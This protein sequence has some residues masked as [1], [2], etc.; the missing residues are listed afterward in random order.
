[1]ENY[2]KEYCASCDT[3]LKTK[4]P[5][6]KPKAGLKPQQWDNN[7]PGQAIA[8][9]LATMT[10]SYDGFKY[11]MLITDGMSKFTELCPLRNMTAP[12]VVKNIERNW[13][14]RHGIPTTLLTDQGTQV[15]GVEVRDLCE[16]YNIKKQ[17]SSPYH[18]EGD[19]ISERPIGVMKGLF[20]RKIADDNMAQRKWTDLVPGVQLAMNQKIHSSTGTSPFQLMYGDNKR[21][22]TTKPH[23]QGTFAPDQRLNTE[24]RGYSK[25]MSIAKAQQK[26]KSTSE[27]MKTQYNKTI[28]ESVL[29][30]GDLVYIKREQTKKGVSK[31]LSTTYHELSRVVEVSHPIYKIRRVNSGKEG[32]V[33][34][35]RLKKKTL[36]DDQNKMV[37]S[38]PQQEP[39]NP[40]YNT[41]ED[42][43]DDDYEYPTVINNSVLDPNTTEEPTNAAPPPQPDHDRIILSE[44]RNEEI[45]ELPPQASQQEPAAAGRSFDDDGRLL[46]TRTKR[47]T[48]RE[49]YQY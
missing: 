44:Q 18:P 5:N 20:R 12:S 28:S 6:K 22:D 17:R 39:L 15:D 47:S 29:S 21:F 25:E 7:E 9:D 13:I 37:E 38:H 24:E 45:A 43:W 49:D 31:K 11:I 23:L 27:K 34:H 2:I 33:H 30:K 4:S 14:A 42:G 8:L 16:R 26:L 46:S 35:N 41:I 32:W 19:G 40:G 1:M 10:P 3:C 36:F 48:Q